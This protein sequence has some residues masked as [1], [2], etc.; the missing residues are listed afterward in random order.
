MELVPYGNEHRWLTEALETDERVMAEL[1]G[2]WPRGAIPAIHGRRLKS[3]AGGTWWYRFAPEMDQ[4]P[5]AMVG[6]FAPDLDGTPTGEAGWWILAARQGRGWA[7]EDL[8][9]VLDRAQADSRWGP[10][11]AFPGVTNGPSNAL[12]RKFG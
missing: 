1:G 9:M 11:H 4:P 12:C 5:V 3:I 2:A 7:R 6:I 8:G 10:I